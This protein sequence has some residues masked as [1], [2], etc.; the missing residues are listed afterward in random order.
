VLDDA[1]AKRGKVVGLND[2]IIK[3]EAGIG[4]TVAGYSDDSVTRSRLRAYRST[5]SRTGYGISQA[6]ACR[7]LDALTKR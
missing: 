1:H 3:T 4:V 6:F 2:P 7:K 5:A